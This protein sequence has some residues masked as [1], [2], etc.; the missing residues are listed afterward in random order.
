MH[1]KR[2]GTNTAMAFLAVVAVLTVVV[3]PVLDHH[4]AERQA[5]HGHVFL[6][7]VTP[8]HAHMAD[9]SHAHVAGESIAVGVV[10]TGDND[11]TGL[12]I[13]NVSPPDP[14]N[15]D[16]GAPALHL[17]GV[18]THDDMPSGVTAIPLMRP[19]IA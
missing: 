5:T 8:D 14:F 2:K 12:I 4:F 3:G 1:W 7:E 11:V 19:P 16:H 18:I 6:D 10:A 17:A 15:F 9:E 13:D